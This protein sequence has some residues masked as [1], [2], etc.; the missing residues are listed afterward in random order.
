M[1]SDLSKNIFVNYHTTTDQPSMVRIYQPRPN[2]GTGTSSSSSSSNTTG[3]GGGGGG[4]GGSAEQGTA[5]P[6][7]VLGTSIKYAVEVDRY[8]HTVLL[9]DLV[10]D[11]T[12]TF[13]AGMFEHH[14]RN[15]SF[16]TAPS[17]STAS[18]SFLNGGDDGNGEV[19]RQLSRLAAARQPP[20]LFAIHGGDVAYANN[21]PTCYRVWD[22]WLDDW[23]QIMVTTE[24]NAI[25]FTVAIANHES[26]QEAWGDSLPKQ[27]VTSYFSLFAQEDVGDA[28]SNVAAR[29]TS[30]VHMAGP[31]V[32][33]VVLDSRHVVPWETQVPWLEKQL[34]PGNPLAGANLKIAVYHMP[35]YSGTDSDSCIFGSVGNEFQRGQQAW[36]PTFDKHH[37]S[38]A[39]EHHVHLFK[40]TK[41]LR[42]FTLAVQRRPTD[43]AADGAG[44]GDVDVGVNA[45]EDKDGGG[46]E[47]GGDP[48]VVYMGGGAWGAALHKAVA[49]CTAE[50]QA[51]D[52]RVG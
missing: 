48:G 27:S 4:G 20:P 51:S 52:A 30:H 29:T 12:Y 41:P 28:A 7:V 1:A 31:S 43:S 15:I 36:V 46:G 9:T 10:A 25:P 33:L 18:V 24:G 37:F 21:F 17:D 23:E 35:L 34:A 40:R 16:K 47:G 42:N 38:I 13:N 22:K 39:F 14:G 19:K 8:I 6:M 50:E 32:G 26:G 49:T 44:G 45:G 5:A 11:A 2:V 3:G